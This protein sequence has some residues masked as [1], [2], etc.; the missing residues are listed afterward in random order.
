MKFVVVL[1][2]ID[3]FCFTFV[4]TVMSYRISECLGFSRILIAPSV[5]QVGKNRLFM[6]YQIQFKT[7]E[8]LIWVGHDPVQV[9]TGRSVMGLQMT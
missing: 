1:H 6:F 2:E 8:R 5:P 7:R 4:P 3:P 9:Q